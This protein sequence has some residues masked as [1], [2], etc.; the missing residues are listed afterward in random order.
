M[1]KNFFQKPCRL[2]DNVGNFGSARQTT[3]DN[4]RD[5]EKMRF[6]CWISKG[7]I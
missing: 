5:A 2:S 1:F 7:R 6:A 4:K 3:G